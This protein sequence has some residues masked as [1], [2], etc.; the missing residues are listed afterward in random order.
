MYAGWGARCF[1][2]QGKQIDFIRLPVANVTKLAFGGPDL[3]TA[4][5][6]TAA[7]G[8]SMKERAEQP[9]AGD[10]FSCRMNIAGVATTPF[11]TK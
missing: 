10:L 5:F 6:T 9:F 11:K 8:L 4:Y 1:N 2:P 7:Q 3:K